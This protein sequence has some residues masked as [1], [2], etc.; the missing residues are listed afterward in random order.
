MQS[1][2]HAVVGAAFSAVLVTALWP[3]VEFST[4]AALWIYGVGLS[5]LVDLDHFLVARL[6]VGD[7]R[8]LRRVLARP[9][10]AVWDQAWIFPE[11]DLTELNRLL[12][13]AV[14][15]GALVTGTWTITP[16]LSAYTAVVLYV[17]VVADLLR[18]NEVL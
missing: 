18:D 14:L 11:E 13:H 1:K 9:A 10:A 15:G 4:A 5:V 7:W 3:A 17:H 6:T 12:S 8:H 2:A 16:T